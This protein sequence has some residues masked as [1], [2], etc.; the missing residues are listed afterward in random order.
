LNFAELDE[1]F[2]R[3]NRSCTGE[4]HFNEWIKEINYV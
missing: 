1:L 3:V 2:W 4:I